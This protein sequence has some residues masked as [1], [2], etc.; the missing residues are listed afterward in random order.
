MFTNN[1]SNKLPALRHKSFAPTP[2]MPSKTRHNDYFFDSTLKTRI[3]N[4]ATPDG[5]SGASLNLNSIVSSQVEEDI[6][7]RNFKSRTTAP[8]KVNPKMLLDKIPARMRVP[9]EGV[10]S[11]GEDSQIIDL[12]IKMPRQDLDTMAARQ[13]SQFEDDVP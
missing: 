4:Y 11:F 2:K 6:R 1:K 8:L 7:K 9:S 3:T 13:M 5:R 12:K 10:E